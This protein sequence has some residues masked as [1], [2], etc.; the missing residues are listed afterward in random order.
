MAGAFSINVLGLDNLLK[1]MEAVST[2]TREKVYAE[3]EGAAYNIV[4]NA[5]RRVPKDMGQLSNA[6]TVHPIDEKTFEVVAQ[7]FYAP[8][9]EFGTGA[10]AANYLASQDEELKAYAM[11]FYVNGQGRMTPRPF[12]FPAFEQEKKKM[13]ENIKAIIQGL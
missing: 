2:E 6:I 13:I 12:F 9:V 8:Y 10:K 4:E 3:V 7:K 5:A 11:Q 1:R